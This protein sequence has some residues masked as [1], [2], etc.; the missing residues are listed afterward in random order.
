MNTRIITTALRRRGTRL[1]LCGACAAALATTAMTVPSASAATH[2]SLAGPP[3]P[4]SLI[5]GTGN[6]TCKTATGEIGFDPTSITGGL[7][8]RR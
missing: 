6:P 2:P 4:T 1:L 5:I 3:N 7:S 8:Q